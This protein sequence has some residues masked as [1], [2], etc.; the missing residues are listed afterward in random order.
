MIDCNTFHETKS[1][2]KYY[3]G[4]KQDALRYLDKMIRSL[5]FSLEGQKWDSNIH[6]THSGMKL[7]LQQLK[8][9]R[10]LVDRI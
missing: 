2:R 4:K 9:A 10:K 1:E 6:M 8:N 3:E 5:E 7:E